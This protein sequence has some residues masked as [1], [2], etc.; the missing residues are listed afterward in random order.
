LIFAI[1]TYLTIWYL[2]NQSISDHGSLER[3]DQRTTDVKIKRLEEIKT[4]CRRDNIVPG[5]L[6]TKEN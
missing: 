3:E 1:R 4:A 5:I 2:S 6:I